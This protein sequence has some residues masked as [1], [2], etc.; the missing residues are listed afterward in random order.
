MNN[1]NNIYKNNIEKKSLFLNTELLF[2]IY[3]NKK[4]QK[5]E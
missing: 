4:T 2:Q 5:N 1:K 3:K